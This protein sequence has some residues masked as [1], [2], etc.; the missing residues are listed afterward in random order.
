[1]FQSW[2]QMRRL[3]QQLSQPSPAVRIT[4]IH[5]LGHIGSREAVQLL[6]N[7]LNDRERSVGKEAALA[8]GQTGN[9]E[10]LLPLLNWYGAV[11][12]AVLQ[13]PLVKLGALAPNQL[14][15]A[16]QAPSNTVRRAAAFTLGEMR[17]TAAVAP[18]HKAL[19]DQDHLV[20]ISVV[21]ALGK[22]GDPQSV[23]FLVQEY[24][25]LSP[26]VDDKSKKGFIIRALRDIGTKEACA[27]LIKVLEEPHYDLRKDA[28]DALIALKWEPLTNGQK[29]LLAIGQ[30]DWKTVSS[31]GSAAV[32]PL[33]DFFKQASFLD[34]FHRSQAAHAL[35]TLGDPIAI[36][37][38]LEELRKPNGVREGVMR[39]LAQLKVVDSVDLIVACAKTE[40]SGGRAVV[41]SLEQLLKDADVLSRLQ[42]RTLHQ[43]LNLLSASELEY[44]NDY[45]NDS[46]RVP[47]SC[48]HLH[49]LA[50]QELA[51][52]G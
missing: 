39:G 48:E 10:A 16:L 18:L 4:A 27:A 11:A 7:M 32:E 33:I 45:D 35:G 6:A 13:G 40:S 30:G 43:I 12:P 29:A 41:E 49:Q 50:Q 15:A 19:H 31:L 26:S 38:L 46:V 2:F 34:S 23:Q 21:Q 25:Q 37:L 3:K 42:S 52:R 24:E 47:V 17:L 14:L 8:L 20:Q 1:M 51:R 5:E 9:P 28:S 22:I 44:A 36:P